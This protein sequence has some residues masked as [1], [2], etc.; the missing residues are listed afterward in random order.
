MVDP[1]F[2]NQQNLP[3]NVQDTDYIFLFPM[4]FPSNRQHHES[5]DLSRIY[6]LGAL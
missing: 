6:P 1:S 4:G 5:E 3:G 2:Y